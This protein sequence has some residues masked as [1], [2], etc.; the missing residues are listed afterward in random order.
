MGTTE[1]GR[2]AGKRENRAVRMTM[3]DSRSII[4]IDNQHCLRGVID[5]IV[6]QEVVLQ[7][8]HDH[9]LIG[10]GSREIRDQ[11]WIGSEFVRPIEQAALTPTRQGH[12]E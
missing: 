8:M 5:P 1:L 4:D 11:K 10:I 7:Q 9:P 12:E 3:H 6:E 2:H